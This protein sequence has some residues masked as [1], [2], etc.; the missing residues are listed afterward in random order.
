MGFG[1]T[2]LWVGQ[3]KYLSDC[4]KHKIEKK[5][6]YSSIFWGA[7]FFASFLSSILNA[8]VLGSYPQEYLYITC[9]LISLLATI[10]MIFLPKIQIEEQE[11]K[12]E[13]TGKSDIKEQEKHGIIK[14]ISD[15]QMILTYGISLATALS[16][17]FRL[18]GLFSFLTLT[19]S[20][21][22]IQNKFK[23]ASYAQA[24]LGLGQLIGSLVSKIHTFRIKCKLL[25]EQNSPKVQKLLLS[26]DYL[27]Q[28]LLHSS[29]L[30]SQ[31]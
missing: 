26:T 22:T 6:V 21:E 23:N 27:T 3:G 11:Q 5:G 16:L 4:S 24:F 8:L 10:L 31:I 17:A 28:L 25:W 14:L 15:K 29:S 19:Q 12:D 1:A 30:L 13:R 20:N 9:S 7:M 18:S 2:L